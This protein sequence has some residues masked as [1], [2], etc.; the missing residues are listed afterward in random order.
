MI[1]LIDL[2]SILYKAVY[3]VV[4]IQE[5][6][7]A[8]ST[9][10]AKFEEREQ[11]KA[12]AQQWLSEQVYNEGLNRCENE[13]LKILDYLDELSGSKVEGSE[14]F[15]TTCER[16]FR[17]N[18]SK[19]YK[20]NRKRNE[21][22]WL[23]REHYRFNGAKYSNT[24][25]ADDLI[26]IRA[27]ALGVGNYIV[28]SPDKDLRQ[29][30]GHYWSYY[31][32]KSKDFHGDYILNEYGFHETEY[33]QKEIEFIPKEEAERMFWK[34]MLTGDTSDNIQGL[35]GVG[36]KTAEKILSNSANPFITTAREYLKRGSKKEFRTNFKLLKLKA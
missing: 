32:V 1:A 31:S 28:V 21:Y 11:A 35:K 23:L 36:D 17:K 2:D 24:L 12:H 34:Q 3:R 33:K 20:A 30:G 5:M 8:L 19:T 26:S 6:R 25:E 7:N 29:I 18:L 10:F 22:V 16:S 15:I 14:L 9:A 27:N 13:I 4:S